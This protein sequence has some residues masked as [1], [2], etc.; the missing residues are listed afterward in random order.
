MEYLIL[1]RMD[2]W[3]KATKAPPFG[4]DPLW[5]VNPLGAI[6][7]YTLKLWRKYW[8]Y[9]MKSFDFVCAVDEAWG[10]TRYKRF[11]GGIG[12]NIKGS[13]NALLHVF[14]GPV[15]V[16]TAE[17]AEIEAIMYVVSVS[18]TI[19]T[20]G[21]RMVIYSDSVNPLEII[22]IGLRTYVP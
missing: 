8:R 14:F 10:M 12:G 19:L 1:T 5:R 16:S 21:K 18:S 17:E 7:L 2:K 11:M 22:R 3:G 13:N 9:K 6:A 20:E 15:Q 4:N